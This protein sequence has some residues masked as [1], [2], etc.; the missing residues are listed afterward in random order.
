MAKQQILLVDADSSSARVLEVSLRS[1]GFTVTSADSAESA[2]GKLEHG[3]PDL[4]LTDTRLPGVD[5]FAFVRDL[6][7]R[8][9]LADVPIVF[10]TEQGALED[11]LRGLELGVDDY[12]AKPIFVREVVTRVHMLLARK[13]QQRIATESV[14]RTRFSGSLE[15]VAVVD[16]LQTIAISGKSGVAAVRRGDREAKLY[17]R[18][19][20]LVDAEVGDLRG[21][22]AVYRTITWTTGTFDL[23]FRPVERAS[24]IDATMNGLLMEGLRR[25]DELGRLSEQLPPEN[26]IIDIDHDA[27]LGRLN[28]IPDELN[29]VLRL[30]D[31][32]RTLLDLI[33]GSPFDDLS[34]M[35]VLSKF[36]F[37]GLLIAVESEPEPE[38]AP[39][40]AVDG[41]EA[42]VAAV[43][44]A[45]VVLRP[46]AGT[47]S[48][49]GPSVPSPPSDSRVSSPREVD[50]DNSQAPIV[51][52]TLVPSAPAPQLVTHSEPV[53]GNA[54]VESERR[55][56]VTASGAILESEA[57]P[58]LPALS[59]RLPALQSG[60]SRAPAAGEQPKV[61]PKVILNVGEGSAHS[62]SSAAPQPQEGTR[63]TGGTA[64]GAGYG[65]PAYPGPQLNG[66]SSKGSDGLDGSA[67]G[68]G[69]VPHAA[70]APSRSL[71]DV[72]AGSSDPAMRAQSAMG[73]GQIE[74]GAR[75]ASGHFAPA[76][77]GA[78]STHPTTP[79]APPTPPLPAPDSGPYPLDS[80]AAPPPAA[81]ERHTLP[82]SPSP[83][84]SQFEPVRAPSVRQTA[85]GGLAVQPLRSAAEGGVTVEARSPS[86][87]STDTDI[88]ATQGA[89]PSSVRDT[90]EGWG[91]GSDDSAL[92]PGV[93]SI[94]AEEPGPHAVSP[95]EPPTSERDAS[96]LLEPD[97]L[98]GPAS[99]ADFFDAGDE[100]TYAGGPRS[101]I[102]ARDDTGDNELVEPELTAPVPYRSTPAQQARMRK[103]TLL[104]GALLTIAAG[105]LLVVLWRNLVPSDESAEVSDRIA[106]ENAATPSD[107]V[108]AEWEPAAHT[109][110]PQAPT[111]PSSEPGT[112][113]EEVPGAT[114]APAEAEARF[115][116]DGVVPAPSRAA[117]AP[118]APAAPK[119]AEPRTSPA[120]RAPA[121]SARR[122]AAEPRLGSPARQP[123]AKPARA[124]PK[125]RPAPAPKAPPPAASPVAAPKPPPQPPRSS[126]DK[127]PTAAYPPL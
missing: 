18:S 5:G 88:T 51:A 127:P 48:E 125:P 54:S 58:T 56:P 72:A 123:P 120:S 33:D 34:T 46:S 91:R 80:W 86:L 121:V 103:G 73:A 41:L 25:V 85:M 60:A 1:A 61:T 97:P 116:P 76:P 28:E 83:A 87:P 90:A 45:D 67:N 38:P 102:P 108:R 78:L 84:V 49:T 117:P 65:R 114:A 13:N 104:V 112:A 47:R 82:S 93:D 16:L 99:E 107:D 43:E 92:D 21:E 40:P 94:E 29:G 7:T 96:D 37:E 19:G 122:P 17:F 119:A 20:Q 69:H 24:V 8:S 59:G 52:E 50:G 124:A 126:A 10:L 115:A 109:S 31:G 75:P 15:D 32:K 79:R 63:S 12:L 27:L 118:V 62:G 3:A 22:E 66:Q 111:E 23:E 110:E 4:I 68:R 9:D 55:T 74:H 6:R 101:S 2:L 36:Y 77:D 98:E 100:G 30:I 42:A 11:K 95:S 105:P 39:V 35:T 64:G 53:R 57:Q 81:E 14:A 89:M 106:I 44:A 26:T 70:S 113:E 71:P